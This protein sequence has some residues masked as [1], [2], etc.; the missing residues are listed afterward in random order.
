MWQISAQ[1]TVNKCVQY[2]NSNTPNTIAV[3]NSNERKQTRSLDENLLYRGSSLMSFFTSFHCDVKVMSG[4][5]DSSRWNIS[6]FFFVSALT[7]SSCSVC[8]SERSSSSQSDHR[9]SF[10][11]SFLFSCQEPST[12]RTYTKCTIT[13][14]S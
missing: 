8:F 1:L 7:C 2:D 6:R 11:N 5:S 4:V 3:N 9:W 14:K 10:R 13:Q 12:L